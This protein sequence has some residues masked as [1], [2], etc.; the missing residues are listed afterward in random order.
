MTALDHLL[1]LMER[2]V[3]LAALLPSDLTDI[4]ES[5]IDAV[6]SI[7][8]ITAEMDRTGT[9]IDILIER[10]GKSLGSSVRQISCGGFVSVSDGIGG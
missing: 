6:T 3:K 9:E 1:A 8:V 2:T 10:I 5:D 7:E 4:D